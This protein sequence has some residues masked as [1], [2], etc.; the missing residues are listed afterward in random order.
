MND[1]QQPAQRHR[2]RHMDWATG[3]LRMAMLI[4]QVPVAL[5]SFSSHGASPRELCRS[6]TLVPRG[7]MVHGV[8]SAETVA[9]QRVT[10]E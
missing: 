8:W 4:L 6:E 1:H 5:Y 9:G 3:A 7:R 10:F 2:A